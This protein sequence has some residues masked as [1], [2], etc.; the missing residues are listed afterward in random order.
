MN[1]CQKSF[2]KSSVVVMVFHKEDEKWFL[3]ARKWI[4]GQNCKTRRHG[5]MAAVQ[6]QPFGTGESKK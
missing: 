5:N 3:E 1:Y 6:F 2:I 4:L